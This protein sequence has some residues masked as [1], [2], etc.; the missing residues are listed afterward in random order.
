MSGVCADAKLTVAIHGLFLGCRW[1]QSIAASTGMV[2][3]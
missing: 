1:I 2:P 3:R